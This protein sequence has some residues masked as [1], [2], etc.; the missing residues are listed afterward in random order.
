MAM[1]HL[2]QLQL[3]DAELLTLGKAR[4]QLEKQTGEQPSFFD[5]LIAETTP[6]N[7]A[8]RAT[9]DLFQALHEQLHKDMPDVVVKA[10]ID[11]PDIF[12]HIVPEAWWQEEVE[13]CQQLHAMLAHWATNGRRPRSANEVLDFLQRAQANNE[14]TLPL[15]QDTTGSLDAV[16]LLTIH[17]AKGLEF[18]VVYI[19]GVENYRG[20]SSSPNIVFEPQ[21]APKP[22]F[23]LFLKKHSG[24]DSTK[25]L[26]YKLFWEDPRLLNERLRLQYVGL[27]RAKQQ[28][29]LFTGPKSFPYL[30]PQLFQGLV[31]LNDPLATSSTATLSPN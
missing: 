21:Y 29:H 9:Q 11:T 1:V 18:P 17:A 22:G 2:L 20:R 10:L 15:S 16:M 8:L 30:H 14:L 7:N 5:T 3:S 27:T 24:Q 25:N 13:N 28:L 4:L 12:R 31:T 23:G 19:A 6:K 26:I